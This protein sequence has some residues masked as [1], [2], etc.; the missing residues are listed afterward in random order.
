MVDGRWLLLDRRWTT[1]DYHGARAR[2]SHDVR[3]LLAQQGGE[4]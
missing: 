3:R 1:L 4:C 2:Q